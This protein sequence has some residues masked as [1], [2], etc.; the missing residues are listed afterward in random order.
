MQQNNLRLPEQNSITLVGR[1]TR[2]PE[3]RFTAKG[4]AVCSFDLAV[5][6][7]YKSVSGEWKDDTT[8]IGIVV[9]AWSGRNKQRFE[10]AAQLPF[11]QD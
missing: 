9:W 8:F 3:V 7:R 2:D 4:D 11:E 10:E 6:R 5:N 1:L